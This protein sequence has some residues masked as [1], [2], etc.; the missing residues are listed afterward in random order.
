MKPSTALIALAATALVA[1]CQTPG[2]PSVLPPGLEVQPQENWVNTLS[3]RGV[4]IYECR[5]DG[6][7]LRWTLL[8]PDAD[9]FESNGRLFGHHGA[10]PSWKAA[11]GSL[12]VGKVLTRADAPVAGA[13][14]WL[15]LET[16][17]TAGKGALDTVTLIRRVN[18]RGGAAPGTGCSTQSQGAQV[19]VPYTADYVLYSG[20]ST[21]AASSSAM[22][23]PSPRRTHF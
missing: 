6:G 21:P 1:A 2:L 17:S 18:T 15:L 10:G 19:R 12:V 7:P 11:D 23:L 5:N 8:A 9:L 20:R 13:I 22:D 3:A 16:R 14:P 4:Q